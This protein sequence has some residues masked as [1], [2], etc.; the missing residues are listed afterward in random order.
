[1]ALGHRGTSYLESSTAV[2][3]V[4]EFFIG[5][6]IGVFVASKV[7]TNKINS[8]T[9]AAPS[10]PIP[11][12]GCF[13]FHAADP[14][15]AGTEVDSRTAPIDRTSLWVDLVSGAVFHLLFTPAASSDFTDFAW[16]PASSP[17][18]QPRVLVIFSG[19]RWLLSWCLLD[20]VASPGTQVQASSPTSGD[21]SSN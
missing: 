12:A 20:S 14:D 15:L 16:P 17:L 4:V 2:I 18:Q 6:F 7:S 1:M 8:P 21:S 19:V 5:V 13:S 9:Q 10:P 3:V 11:I